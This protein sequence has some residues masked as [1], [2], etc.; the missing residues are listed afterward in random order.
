MI[1]CNFEQVGESGTAI[2]IQ[3]LIPGTTEGLTTG[4]TVAQADQIMVYDSLKADYVTYFLYKNARSANVKDYKWCSTTSGNPVADKTFKNGDAFWYYSLASSDV[5]MQLAG[6]VSAA[7]TQ[8][9]TIVPGYSMIGDAFPANF[10][11]NSLGVEYWTAAVGNGAVAGGTVA[12]A[13]QIMIY[14]AAKADYVTYFLYK[15]ARSANAKDYKWC[16]TTSGN[17]AVDAS[18]EVMPP[19][20]GAWYYHIGQGFTLTAPTPVVDAE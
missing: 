18:A 14:D 4:G 2:S 5:I 20:K 7:A 15:N 11:P 1:A 6:Q 8:S 13:D 17:P 19:A 9:I 12:Q 16:A 10:N 3:D